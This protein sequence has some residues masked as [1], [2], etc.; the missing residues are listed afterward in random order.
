MTL[1]RSYENITSR[2]GK[3]FSADYLMPLLYPDL[4]AGSFLYLKRIRAGLF[5]DQAWGK[6]NY[7]GRIVNNNYIIEFHDRNE[8]FRSFGI[9]LI[10]DFYVLRIPY[11]ISAGVQS[12]FRSFSEAP[13]FRL[14]FNIDIYGMNI[15]RRR[16]I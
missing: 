14:L 13:Y 11:M 1:P 12:A 9:E 4:T 10:S 5:Y 7:L 15:G 16:G 8:T 3:F 6:G 2:N